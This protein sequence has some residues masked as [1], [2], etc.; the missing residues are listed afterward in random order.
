MDN[1]SFLFAFFGIP[2]TIGLILGGIVALFALAFAINLLCSA[3]IGRIIRSVKDRR[4]R[5]AATNDETPVI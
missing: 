4:T 2:L 5:A 1:G 3:T